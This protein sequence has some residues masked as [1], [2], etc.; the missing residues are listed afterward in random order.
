[1][2]LCASVFIGEYL[3]Y[4]PISDFD[5]SG[6]LNGAEID[7]S[8]TANGSYTYDAVLL[9][10]VCLPSSVVVYVDPTYD[11]YVTEAY[12]LSRFRYADQTHYA[13]Q[14]AMFLEMRSFKNVD[15]CGSEGLARILNDTERSGSTVLVV[16]S[17][18]L[19]REVY[20]GTS[21]CLLIKWMESG[22]TLYWV[23]S[24]IGKFYTDSDGLHVVQDNQNLFFGTECIN[25]DGPQAAKGPIDNGFTDALTLKNSDLSN[26]LDLSKVPGALGMGYAADGFASMAF[27]E[28][29]A[30]ELCI[31]AGGFDIDQVEDMAQ[32]IATGICH[33]SKIASHIEG[34]VSHGTVSGTMECPSDMTEATLYLYIGG[35]YPRYG[36]VFHLV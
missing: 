33:S 10:D 7:Y 22:G 34:T 11:K 32:T 14:L 20:D 17:Y 29:G 9:D 15:Q 18:A 24:E 1:M 28:F 30:G 36:E 2:I 4:N 12:E 23:G 21:D 5:A 27:I 25:T 16:T 13:E 6:E 26:G 3:T 8:V 19:P 35:T 31:V